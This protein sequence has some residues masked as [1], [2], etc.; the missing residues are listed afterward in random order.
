M[1]NID[2]SV[3]HR[4]VLAL[5]VTVQQDTPKGTWVTATGTKL[6][7]N[8]LPLGITQYDAATGETVAVTVIGT[9]SMNLDGIAESQV[10][11]GDAITFDAGSVAVKPAAEAASILMDVRGVVL[12]D[13]A[14][15]G[16]AEVLLR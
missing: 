8:S 9:A 16:H 13:A 10:M 15:T 4:S 14:A 2:K 5:P 3:Q 1:Q 11:A 6:T 7:A 12:Y